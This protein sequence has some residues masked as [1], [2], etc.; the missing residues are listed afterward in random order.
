M[1]NISPKSL[2]VCLLIRIFAP[3]RLTLKIRLWRAIH[4]TRYHLGLLRKECGLAYCVHRFKVLL[5]LTKFFIVQRIPLISGEESSQ[6]WGLS[7]LFQ[8]DDVTP[9][10]RGI[11]ALVVV[12]NSVGK[13]VCLTLA[14]LLGVLL[15][16]D[17]NGLGAM[18][19]IDAID[20]SIQVVTG[21]GA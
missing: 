14:V 16:T 10:C 19:A 15:W 18:Q 2:V 17:D 1:Q 3:R 6:A 21:T 4:I 8:F 13:D 7:F 11:L 9:S 5:R 20:D 12:F